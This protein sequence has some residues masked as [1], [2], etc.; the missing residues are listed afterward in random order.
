VTRIYQW[1]VSLRIRAV[2]VPAF[3]WPDGAERD[4]M[5]AT[6]CDRLEIYLGGRHHFTVRLTGGGFA[7]RAFPPAFA[8]LTLTA[9]QA[10]QPPELRVLGYVGSKLVTTLLMS[11]DTK[12][13]QL[14]LRADHGE[15][16]A[17]GS[18]AT[19]ITFRATD[20]YGSPGRM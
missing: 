15:I 2:I 18:D 17:D 10:R 4:R 11:A 7:V 16:F 20:A 8:N 12:R 9:T 5:I 19:R 6:N 3:F 14:S 1:Q 13:D